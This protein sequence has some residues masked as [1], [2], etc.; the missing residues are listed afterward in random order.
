VATSDPIE[1]AAEILTA[2][3]ANNSVPR[4]ALAALFEGLHSAL[5]RLVDGGGVAPAV[6]EAPEP[7]VSIRKSVTPNY[8]I[9]LDDGC[10]YKSLR[11]HLT[12]LGMTS[13]QYRQ[14]WNLPS[15]YPMVATNY[16]AQ[17]S[18]FVSAPEVRALSSPCAA[19]LHRSYD[20]VRLPLTSPS[21]PALRPLPS[22]QRRASIA[23][24]SVR[25]PDRPP[26][27]G[28]I[29]N[30]PRGTL[31]HWLSAPSGRTVKFKTFGN[32]ACHLPE[33]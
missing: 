9:C 6:I 12:K 15:D 11:R 29:D 30:S 26:A 7:A 13:E 25:R 8:L 20:P 32:S 10:Q 2:F 5:K 21:T 31:L 33:A 17:R 18:V 27:T 23:S 24:P 22:C 4:A 19:R 3:V 14:K 16:A 1:L 28:T